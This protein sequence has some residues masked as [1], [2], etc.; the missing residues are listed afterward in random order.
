VERERDGGVEKMFDLRD[1]DVNGLE[2]LN[3]LLVFVKFES[4]HSVVPMLSEKDVAIDV[5]W[6]CDKF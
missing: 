3:I 1:D 5:F 2:S 6:N 4:D